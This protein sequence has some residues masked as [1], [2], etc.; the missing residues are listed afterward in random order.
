[1]STETSKG[2]RR[3]EKATKPSPLLIEDV[4][5]IILQY[6]ILDFEANIN[7][8]K[9]YQKSFRRQISTCA[10][11]SRTWRLPVQKILFT[12]VDLRSRQKLLSIQDVFSIKKRQGNFLRSIVR[13]L[14]IRID[15]LERTGNIRPSDLPV[16]MKHFPLLYGLRLELDQV[17]SFSDAV[18]RA[19][20]TTPPIQALMLSQGRPNTR[21]YRGEY[22]CT[23]VQLLNQ[24]P[25][26]KLRHFVMS[27]GLAVGCPSTKHPPPKHQFVEVRVHA[28]VNCQHHPKHSTI[29]WF[30]QNSESSLRILSIS[31]KR[32]TPPLFSQEM[33]DNL[34]SLEYNSIVRYLKPSLLPTNL[35][36]LMW[37]EVDLLYNNNLPMIPQ[38][39]LDHLPFLTHI[40]LSATQCGGRNTQPR[41]KFHSPHAKFPL[42]RSLR[43]ITVI[44][45]QFDQYEKPHRQCWCE[46]ILGGEIEVYFFETLQDYKRHQPV[47][48]IPRT[49]S[50]SPT[51]STLE[52]Y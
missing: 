13:S 7:G 6:L 23:Y 35:R 3:F 38:F 16:C 2:G 40:R 29:H 30:F 25:H 28:D 45:I 18:I 42:P 36:E 48:L 21:L 47:P 14:R 22:T 11:I 1:M 8:L 46:E 39:I 34:L 43:R 41:W 52:Y 19:L 44:N 31:E 17:E 15:G 5:V 50:P 27:R 26:W 9:S 33:K 49:F 32:Y 4:I 10:L 12:E 37:V 20:Q 51:L 24:V